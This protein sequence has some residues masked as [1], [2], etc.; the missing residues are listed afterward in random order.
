VTFQWLTYAEVTPVPA[1][2][3]LRQNGET[4]RLGFTA[5]D[6]G[7]HLV[8]EDVAQPRQ[9]WD[10]PNPGLRRIVIHVTTPAAT[11]ARLHVVATP[12]IGP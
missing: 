4:L 2:A 9:A 3:T 12:G 10:S 5:T 7:A 8:V 1:G 11:T 6:P